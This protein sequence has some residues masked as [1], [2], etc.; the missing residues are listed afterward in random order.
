M[1]QLN[2]IEL[3]PDEM[4]IAAV[5]ALGRNDRHL[6]ASTAYQ[7]AVDCKHTQGQH[8]HC[9]SMKAATTHMLKTGQ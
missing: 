1:Q 6:I 2:L 5:K 8:R 3:T 7:G 9:K 4:R